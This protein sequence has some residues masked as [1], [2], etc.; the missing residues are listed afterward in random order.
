MVSPM[1]IT[2]ITATFLPAHNGTAQVCFR[3][4][5]ELVRRGH[6]VHVFTP[7]YPGAPHD[8][9]MG[10]VA[11]HRLQPLLRS[12]NAALLPQ[13]VGVLRGF[14]IIH[15]HYPFLGGEVSALAA[16]LQRTPLVVTYHQDVLLHGPMGLIEKALRLTAG[17]AALRRA[18]RVLFTSA[19]YGRASYAGPLLHGRESAICELPNGVDP[20]AFTPGPP[21]ADLAAQCRLAPG[22]RAL[23]LVAALDRAHYFKGV[24]VLLEA[25]AR[26]PEG[27]KAVLV[28]DGDLRGEYQATVARLGLGSRVH[29]AGRVADGALPDYYRLADLTVLPSTTMGEAFGLVLLESLACGTPVVA[30]NLPGV[31]TVVDED[32]DGLLAAPGDAGDLAAKVAVLLATPDRLHDMG[33]HGRAKVQSRYAWPAIGEQ[34]EQ[35]YFGVLPLGSPLAAGYGN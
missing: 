13:L 19:D 8:E 24:P 6:H 30:S 9:I 35:I 22:D 10:G 34:L 17:R 4:A 31:R 29:F 5:L 20:T 18:D 2:Q 15:L 28:G 33:W 23:L 12:G 1:R 21:P 3:N 25:L 32:C 11:V 7:A 26:L 14:D 16:R 27:V